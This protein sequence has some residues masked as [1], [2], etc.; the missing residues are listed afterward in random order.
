M[1]KLAAIIHH[2]ELVHT[3]SDRIENKGVG[4]V[5]TLL[6]PILVHSFEILL[7]IPNRLKQSRRICCCRDDLQSISFFAI[8]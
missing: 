7:P 6:R 4:L 5:D 8:R 1:A 2:G 3:K